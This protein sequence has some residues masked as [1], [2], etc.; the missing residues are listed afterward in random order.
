MIVP[1]HDGNS[2]CAVGKP[3]DAQTTLRISSTDARRQIS[4][5]EADEI[6]QTS[7]VTDWSDILIRL[8]LT[9]AGTKQRNAT[10]TRERSKFATF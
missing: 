10:Q 2:K 5:R 9:D 8:Y 7:D 4:R 1:V 6:S 3:T